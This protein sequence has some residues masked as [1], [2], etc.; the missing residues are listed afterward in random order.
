MNTSGK[1]SLNHKNIHIHCAVARSRSTIS[2]ALLFPNKFSL[3]LLDSTCCSKFLRELQILVCRIQIVCELIKVFVSFLPPSV[4]YYLMD[5]R[6]RY[7]EHKMSTRN[8]DN[9]G[10]KISCAAFKRVLAHPSYE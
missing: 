1:Q 9:F 4:E 8:V 10:K 7:F 2:I 3:C 6:P 5:H